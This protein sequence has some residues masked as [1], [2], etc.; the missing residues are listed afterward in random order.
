MIETYKKQL[1]I[2]MSEKKGKKIPMS[3]I[4]EIVEDIK[5]RKQYS[6]FR[7]K[8]FKDSYVQ[9]SLNAMIITYLKTPSK[10]SVDAWDNN[11]WI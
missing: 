9:R 6:K 4:D 2:V 5:N 1:Q 10:V 11:K 7:E 8:Y 3:K